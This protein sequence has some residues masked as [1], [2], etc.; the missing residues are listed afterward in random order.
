MI[1][2]SHVGTAHL[3]KAQLLALL[4]DPQH[5]QHDLVNEN[6]DLLIGADQV[7]GPTVSDI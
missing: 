3:I 6:V 1:H 5:S 2:A 7:N 4:I